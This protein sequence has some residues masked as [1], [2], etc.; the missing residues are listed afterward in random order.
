MINFTESDFAEVYKESGH[1]RKTTS[2]ALFNDFE[3]TRNR[4]ANL[5][6]GQGETLDLNQVVDTFKNSG[7]KFQSKKDFKEIKIQDFIRELVW[8]LN[9]YPQFTSARLKTYLFYFFKLL[10]KKNSSYG[11]I[12][13]YFKNILTYD[14]EAKKLLHKNYMVALVIERQDEKSGEIKDVIQ[15]EKPISYEHT[16]LSLPVTRNTY[17]LINA[18]SSFWNPLRTML[19]AFKSFFNIAFIPT[20][21]GT[22]LVKCPKFGFLF[23]YG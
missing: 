1:F 18:S 15:R 21:I 14:R 7:T 11:I 2:K 3:F 23:S 4:L 17:F 19:L 22:S 13:D 10:H 16:I 6:D 12:E 5:P 20:E 8:L 9:E